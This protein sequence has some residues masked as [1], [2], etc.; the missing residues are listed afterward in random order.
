MS[1]PL[2]LSWAQSRAHDNLVVTLGK[3]SVTDIF[4]GN[5]YAH[6]PSQ[7]FFNWAVIDA[8]AFDYAADSWGYSYGIASELTEYDWTLRAGLFDMSRVPNGTDLTRA[9]RKYELDAEIE[10]RFEPFGQGLVR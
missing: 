3:F 4:D 2:P 8:G 6:D 5:D 10:R 9:S 1:P 7:D